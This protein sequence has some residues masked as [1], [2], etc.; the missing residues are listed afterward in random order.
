MYHGDWHM[1]QMHG[2]GYYKF[3]DLEYNGNYFVLKSKS[4]ACLDEDKCG[5][6]NEKL[7]VSLSNLNNNSTSC[8]PESGC[9]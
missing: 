8:S 3:K 1:N 2:E 6:P 5:I 4:T 7:N 9:C